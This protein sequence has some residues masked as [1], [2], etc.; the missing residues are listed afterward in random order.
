AL[1]GTHV[2]LRGTTTKAIKAA[3]LRLSDGPTLAMHVTADGFGFELPADAAKPLV[4]D[5]TGTYSFELID[6]EGLVGGQE[7]IYEIRAVADQPPSVTIEQPGANVFVTPTAAVPLKI[8]AK[9]DLAIH[10]IT[11]HAS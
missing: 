6:L 11:L 5:K 9:D 3:S 10:D 8:V 1:R 4:V 7:S 2:A